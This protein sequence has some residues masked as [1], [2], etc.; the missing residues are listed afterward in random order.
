MMKRY[1]IFAVIAFL[2]VSCYKINHGPVGALAPISFNEVS[3][4]IDVAQGE[5][6]VY[7]DLVV[8]SG[9]PV[10]YQ[11]AYG[12]RKANAKT[13]YEME[14]MEIISDKPEIGYCF[15]K[16]GS[17]VLRL[18][19]DNGESIA[20]K[21]FTLNVNS[22]LDEGMLVLC[23]EDGVPGSSLA[24]IKKRTASEERDG[25]REVW[26]DV[27][28]A[29]NPEF[30]LVNATSMFI[31]AASFDGISY[32]HLVISTND[33]T[34]HIFDLDPK[35]MAVVSGADMQPYGTFVKEFSG[36]QVARTGS[37]TFMLGGNGHVFRYDLFTPFVTERTDV[38]SSAGPMEK[39]SGILYGSA[40]STYDRSLFHT[41]SVL[42][43]PGTDGLTTRLD[44]PEGYD[45][46]AVNTDRDANKVYA[47][48]RG[49]SSP[50]HYSI[51][52]TSSAL[53]P[54]TYVTEFD[55]E[56]LN[57]DEDSRFCTSINSNDAYYS[58][59]NKVYR[60]GYTNKPSA[61]PAVT[62]PEG[63]QIRDIAVNYMGE[64]TDPERESLLYVATWNPSRN[65]L[66]G[67]VYVYYISTG[68]LKK[69]YEGICARPLKLLYK[70]RIS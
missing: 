68:D 47:L 13:E 27:F 35:T 22:G 25:A 7:T 5:V 66:K 24:F 70:Y 59:D 30:E 58:F 49:K 67:S 52:S 10:S 61:V 14:T 33:D 45:L 54:F 26:E 69:A 2:A 34:G 23:R 65:G 48:L 56:A 40:T 46:V 32:N 29:I 21:Y 51:Q 60:W 28:A 17:Y 11:W 41:A 55:D 39:C 62:L 53:K 36:R 12:R 37:Y 64:S 1:F 20:Y 18:R 44:V 38:I 42:C 50:S 63:E 9:K 4:V 57:M 3:P 8:N 6:L 15:R 31:S 19:A 43:Q 16:L